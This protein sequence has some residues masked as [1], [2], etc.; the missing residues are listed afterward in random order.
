M[1]KKVLMAYDGSEEGRR[2]IEEGGEMAAM[3]QAEV[4]LLAVISVPRGRVLSDASREHAM[5]VVEG[6]VDILRNDDIEASGG[7]AI[8]EPVDRI[9]EQAREMDCDLIVVG[10]RKLDTLSRWWRGSTGASLVVDA[11][12]SVLVTVQPD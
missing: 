10:H 3:C 11:P 5:Q 7:I 2:V 9:L 4:F 12:C 1:Y 8:G 6:G